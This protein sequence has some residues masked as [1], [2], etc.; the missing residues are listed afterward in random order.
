M[1]SRRG[2]REFAM[3]T[4]YASEIGGGTLEQAADTL[5]TSGEP[6]AS[7]AQE[8]GLRLARAARGR[9]EE[10]DGL[11]SGNSQNWNLD[12]LAV[13]DRIILRLAIAELLTEA[14]VPT[15]V[16]INEAVE[17][18]KKFSTENSSRF[19]NGLLDAVAKKLSGLTDTPNQNEDPKNG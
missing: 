13:L 7:D 10:I 6:V 11:I 1:V 12:R 3:Q 15:K 9:S 8:Y 14:S 5:T 17:I 18:A 19:V 4:L 2:G 16:C